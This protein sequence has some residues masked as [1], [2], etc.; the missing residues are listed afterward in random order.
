MRMLRKSY[1]V[2]PRLQLS[3]ILGANVLALI[4]VCLIVTLN[5]YTQAHLQNYMFALNLPPNHPFSAVLA[6]READ[7]AR[8]CLW[9]GIIQFVLF[10]GTAI[11]VAHRIAGPLYRLE[12]HLNEVGDGKEP[13]DVKFR[14]GDLYRQLAEACNKVMARLR[15]STTQR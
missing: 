3:L 9:I 8:M 10:N 12:R 13:S 6:E 15:G 5:A 14:K 11:F 4:S 1:F 7:Y 2:N